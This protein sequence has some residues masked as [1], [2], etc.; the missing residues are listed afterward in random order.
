MQAARQVREIPAVFKPREVMGEIL[1]HL[2]RTAAYAR[3]STDSECQATS[4]SAQLKFYSNYIKANPKWTYVGIYADEGITGTQMRNRKQFLKLIADAKAGKIDLIVTK[5]ISR[6]ARNTVDCLSVVRDL[7]DNYGVAVFFEKENLLSTDP[8]AQ[9]T[10][11]ILA[12]VAEEESRSISTNMKWRNQKKFEKGE[13]AVG[14]GLYGYFIDDNEYT[15]NPAEAIIVKRIFEDYLK[16]KTINQI[17]RELEADGIKRIRKL[18]HKKGD[19][20]MTVREKW[21]KST[22]MYMLKNERYTG[23]AINQKSYKL[24]V[25]SKTQKNLNDGTVKMYFVEGNH[26]GII[27]KEIFTAVQAEIT[28]RNADDCRDKFASKYAFSQKLFCSICGEQYTRSHYDTVKKGEAKRVVVWQC[29][30]RAKSAKKCRSPKYKERE[31]EDAFIM[32]LH[33]IL[34]DRD[35]IIA[36]IK[37]SVEQAIQAAGD[38]DSEAIAL[39]LKS[40]QDE[41]LELSKFSQ[42]DIRIAELMNEIDLLNNQLDICHQAGTS[43]VAMQYRIEEIAETL[44]RE[45]AIE[46]FD[47]DIFRALVEKCKVDGRMLTVK[48]KVGLELSQD[49]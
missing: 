46:K 21:E 22:I 19:R 5:S 27:S 20:E 39:E 42:N 26:T 15:I 31:I 38:F 18:K 10:L 13:V 11:S 1:T 4:Y 29:K 49:F 17:C 34:C 3:V 12:S 24:D 16:G 14:C 9:L 30:T 41:M 44:E 37:N 25:L 48:F 7:R 32:M 47:P 6:F 40:K 36:E 45:D 35:S 8:T 2:L 28:R 33:E 43:I 23:D